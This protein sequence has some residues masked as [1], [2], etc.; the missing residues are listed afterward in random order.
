MT[1]SAVLSPVEIE[2]RIAEQEHSSANVPNPAHLEY[3]H[4]D[5]VLKLANLILERFKCR[6]DAYAERIGGGYKTAG[7]YRGR[8]RIIDYALTADVVV[9]HLRGKQPVGIYLFDKPGAEVVHF[10]TLDLDDHVGT[11]GWD[12]VVCVAEKLSQVLTKHGM[13]PFSVRSGGGNGIHLHLLFDQPVSARCVR[14]FLDGVLKGAGFTEGTG[15]LG[16]NQVEIFPTRDYCTEYGKL[17][18]LPFG[19]KSVPLNA[20]MEPQ[21]IDEAY[22]WLLDAPVSPLP[23]QDSVHESC[24]DF[25]TQH[26]VE[27][28]DSRASNT[29]GMQES[30]RTWGVPITLNTPRWGAFALKERPETIKEGGRDSEVFDLACELHRMGFTEAE[31]REQVHDFNLARCVPPLDRSTVETKVKSAWSYNTADAARN[32]KQRAHFEKYFL[33]KVGKRTEVGFFDLSGRGDPLESYLITGFRDMHADKWIKTRGKRALLADLW[34]VNPLTPKFEKVVFHP[35]RSDTNGVLNL[36]RGWKYAPQKGDCSKYLDLVRHIVCQGNSEFYDYLL[37]WMAHGVQKP[38]EK[39]EVCVVVLGPQGTGKSTF[40][41]GYANL[42]DPY[43]FTA[44]KTDHYTGEF[45]RH[46]A[47]AIMVVAEEATCSKNK[48]AHDT[49]KRMITGGTITDRGMYENAHEIDSYHRFIVC[50]NETWV[51]QAAKEER[52]FFVLGISSDHYEDLQYFSAIQDQ[53]KNGGYQALMYHLLNEIDLTGFNPR[54]CPKTEWLDRQKE[55]SMPTWERFLVDE[56]KDGALCENVFKDDLKMRY[57][58]A[59]KGGDL[60]W[61]TFCRKLEEIFKLDGGRH[62]TRRSDGSRV[63]AWRFP[64]LEQGRLLMEQY[65]G[66]KVQWDV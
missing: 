10:A 58:D 37:K 11:V 12:G 56:L 2:N 33:V 24:G 15:G 6:R 27:C 14:G 1:A 48:E 21:P 9:D 64:E 7:D 5:N 57:S 43:M 50:S 55:F 17:I 41:Q 66:R 51:V 28:A 49:L 65:L 35:G 63:S 8:D 16:E 19:R 54:S 61:K 39:P 53:L 40:A 62:Q 47:T 38:H 45:N 30:Q 18:A 4:S 42:F 13:H 25:E 46:L 44:D 34:R 3:E 23:P 20:E 31:V 60:P 32:A 22:Q 52:R 59:V 26:E 29:P 36:W